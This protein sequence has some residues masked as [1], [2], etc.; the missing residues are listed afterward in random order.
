[1]SIDKDNSMKAENMNLNAE[2]VSAKN[3]MTNFP[4]IRIKSE[5]KTNEKFTIRHIPT[6]FK[7]VTGR[8]LIKIKN[9]S[10]KFVRRNYLEYDPSAAKAI[11]ETIHDV[12]GL[13]YSELKSDYVA[14][15]SNLDQAYNK[16]MAD[17]KTEYE[18]MVKI[19]NECNIL[20]SIYRK[21]CEEYGYEF[22]PEL[23][24]I[25]LSS[26]M[27]DDYAEKM[28]FLEKN[29]LKGNNLDQLLQALDGHIGN[30]IGKD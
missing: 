9:G 28:D 2:A 27:I 21:R 7:S 18:K 16:G 14:R 11:F 26:E 22:P 3:K 23:E 24:K 6:R 12:Y 29:K 17:A 13:A 15:I 25:S 1:M 8:T 20:L 30:K 5:F 4:A 19:K 10:M